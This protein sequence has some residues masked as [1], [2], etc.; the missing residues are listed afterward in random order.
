M[1][2]NKNVA[3][4]YNDAMIPVHSRI[5]HGANTYEHDIA[6]EFAKQLITQVIAVLNAEAN[7]CAISY[8]IRD[9]I[10]VIEEHFGSIQC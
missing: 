1:L 5:A 8:P 6:S 2:R 7:K 3:K 9:A 4:A 10:Q